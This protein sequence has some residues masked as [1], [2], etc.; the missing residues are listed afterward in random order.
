MLPRFESSQVRP[1]AVLPDERFHV[2]AQPN[3]A[4]LILP[5]A[6]SFLSLLSLCFFADDHVQSKPNSSGSRRCIFVSSIWED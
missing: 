5:T 4:T 3:Y 1:P 6:G 2:L